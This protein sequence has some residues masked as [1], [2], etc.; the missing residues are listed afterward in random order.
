MNTIKQMTAALIAGEEGQ[1]M[2]EYPLILALISVAAILSL[3]AIGPKIIEA[4]DTAK[5]AL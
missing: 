1:A 5:N 2:V 4:F 3:Q